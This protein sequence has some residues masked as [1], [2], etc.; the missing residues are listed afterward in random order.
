MIQHP[1]PIGTLCLITGTMR[2]TTENLGKQCTVVGNLDL[3]E[4]DDGTEEKVY[5][6]KR[7]GD[8]EVFYAKY[9]HLLPINPDDDE[10]YDTDTE[11]D[12]DKVSELTD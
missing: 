6:I 2:P 5:P 3:V 1:Y 7:Q 8:T 4:F 10:K 11:R 12:T 9:N